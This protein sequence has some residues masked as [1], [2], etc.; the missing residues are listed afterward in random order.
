MDRLAN[1]VIRVAGN[2][3][4]MADVL[5]HGTS[6][7][8]EGNQIVSDGAL[9]PGDLFEK[10]KGYLA[11][12]PGHVYLA[13]NLKYAVI[14]TIGGDMLGMEIPSMKMR[15]R[16]GYLFVVSGADVRDEQPDEDS[17]GELIYNGAEEIRKLGGQPNESHEC[18]W[19]L[20]D[21]ARRYLT[22][23]QYAKVVSGEYIY[24]AN[25]GKKLVKTMSP[26]EKRF[27]IDKFGVHVATK[28]EIPFRSA[29]RFDKAKNPDLKT[30]A[31]NFFE[32][33]ERVA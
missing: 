20:M 6:R 33:A 10:R 22:P 17:I 11:P 14:Y 32:L 29:W 1:I 4:A 9:K 24:W 21:R 13:Q 3:L 27:I 12:V 23:N 7:E 26:E 16:Y 19:W 5:Y 28:G 30:D 15:D 2:F 25:A 8:H 31:S 18:P